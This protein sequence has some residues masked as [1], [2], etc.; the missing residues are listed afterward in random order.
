[1]NKNLEALEDVWDFTYHTTPYYAINCPT[2]NCFECSFEG[3][4]L[5]KSK[6][7]VCPCCG[8][9]NPN[10]VNV[11]RRVSGYLGNP[12]TRPFNKGKSCEVKARVKN[13]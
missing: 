7:F 3:E 10:R 9:N 2:D 11:V 12:N 5:N 1:M 6:G 4:F 8:N 13:L